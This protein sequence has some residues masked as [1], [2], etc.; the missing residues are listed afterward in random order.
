MK[1]SFCTTCK[2]RLFHLSQTLPA[3]LINSSKFFNKEFVILDYN[4]QDGLYNWAKKHLR[5]WERIGV[6]KY[7]RTSTPKFFSPA[8]AKNIAHRNASGDILCNLDCDNFIVEGFCEY[9]IQVFSKP[10]Q[11][12]LSGSEDAFGNNGCCGKI[13]TKKE[14][15]YSV[16]GYDEDKKLNLGWGWDDVN[17]RIRVQEHNRLKTV[18][19]ELNHNIVIDHSNHIRTRGFSDKDILKTRKTSMSAVINLISKRDYIANKGK[20]WGFVEDLKIG[21]D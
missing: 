10:N 12:F 20:K 7:L 3:N 2:D 16:N 8:H 1:I 17:F 21:L 14:H 5:Y 18:Y 15:F 9:L 6:V 11:Y 19:S 4:S 13:A